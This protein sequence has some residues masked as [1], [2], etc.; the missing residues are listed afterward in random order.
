VAIINDQIVAAMRELGTVA[1]PFGQYPAAHGDKLRAYYKPERIE[2][3]FAHRTLLDAGIPVAGSSDYPCGP[4]EPLYAMRSCVTRA[5]RD[6]RVFGESQRISARQALALY[7]TGAAFASAEERSKGRLAPGYLADF[8]VLG[9]DPLAARGDR[10]AEIPVLQTW[11]GG[12]PVW[13]APGYSS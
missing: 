11:V 1:V 2:R 13:S 9:E 12:R 4:L 10:L 6:G 7:T 3:M 5:D 8:V